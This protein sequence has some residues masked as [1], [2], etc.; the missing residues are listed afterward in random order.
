MKKCKLRGILIKQ[1]DYSDSSLILKFFAMEHGLISVL[2]KGIRRKTEK[3]QLNNLCEYELGL[4]EPREGGLWLL[5]EQDLLRD[6]SAFPSSATW[7]AAQ[8]GLELVCQIISSPE[9]Q[10][11]YYQLCL[12]YLGYLQN[13]QSNAVLIFWRFFLRVIKQ[14]G[15][16]S[17]L[18]ECCACHHTGVDYLAYDLYQGGLLC[19]NCY[20]EIDMREHLQCLS[21]TTRI[22]LRMMPEIGK[23]LNELKL[24]S[25][26]LAELNDILCKYWQAHHKQTLKLNSLSVLT[27]FY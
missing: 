12:S 18:D 23:H 1:S 25:T 19:A 9:E 4:Y 7:A 6:Y 26:E 5:Y 17:P 11:V 3:Q 14:S 8:S 13:V 20:A 21:P 22:V 10:H 2:A 15:I 24:G 16:G 27:Q